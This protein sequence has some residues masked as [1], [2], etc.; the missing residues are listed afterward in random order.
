MR[1]GFIVSSPGES[2][3]GRGRLA[4]SIGFGECRLPLAQRDEATTSWPSG[5]AAS[6][7]ERPKPNRAVGYKPCLFHRY[8]GIDDYRGVD[9]LI[10]CCQQGTLL[11]PR[12]QDCDRERKL[13][14]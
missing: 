11:I 9:A 6:A 14:L 13:P 5:S 12:A 4:P 8:L 3:L 7:I 1:A 2:P 10:L